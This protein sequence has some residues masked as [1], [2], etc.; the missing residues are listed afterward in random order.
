MSFLSPHPLRLIHISDI[1]FWRFAFN[2][3][4]LMSKRLLGMGSLVVHRAR[5]FRLER[6]EQVVHRVLSLA[7]D[8]ILITG[9]LT[10]TALPSEFAVARRSLSPW[11]RDPGRVTLIP[12]NHDRYTPGSH[13]ARLFERTFG[14]FAPSASYPWLR[15]VDDQTVILGL[16]PTR[17]S[18][19]A[20][21]RLPERQLERAKELVAG[22][23]PAALRLIVAC[24][25]PL[26]APPGH[27]RDLARKNLINAEAISGWL[28][29][30]GPHLYCC[31]HVHAA[32]AFCPARIPD[33]L[34]LNAGAPLLRD[35]AGDRPPGFLEIVLAGPDVV[36][37]HHCW[38]DEDWQVL[39]LHQ[40]PSFF[41]LTPASLG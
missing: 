30:V 27:R 34:C 13:R 32:W 21:G 39:Q 17:A 15:F 40:S 36:V 22:L 3:L 37:N 14:E 7:P 26:D 12:G 8:H 25:Y 35:H 29:T 41:P 38:K 5:K 28:A 23:N 16:D 9:D 33:Q 24:H 11:L 1:H 4:H 6:I 31:G 2:P 19:T 18:L 20:R 10:T